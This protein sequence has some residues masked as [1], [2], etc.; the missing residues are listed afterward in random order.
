VLILPTA[1]A[2]SLGSEELDAVISHELAHLR[3]R[4]HW[5]RYLELAAVVVFWWNPASWWA[6]NGVR[7]AEEECC[8]A[9]V[10]RSC[11]G[12]SGAYARG[13]VKTMGFLAGADTFFPAVVTGA[14]HFQR[15]ERRIRM[16]MTGGFAR[17]VSAPLWAALSVVAL[18]V[19]LIAPTMAARTEPSAMAADAGVSALTEEPITL[20]L[21]QAVLEDMLKNLASVAELNLL[22]DS[23]VTIGSLNARVSCDYHATPLATVLDDLVGQAGLAWTLDGNVL[24]IH[25]PGQAPLTREGI[26]GRPITLNLRGADLRQVLATMEEIT[27]IHFE[28]DPDVQGT[29][30]VSFVDLPWDQALDLILKANGCAWTSENGGIRVFRDLAQG[31]IPAAVALPQSPPRPSTGVDG[32]QVYHYVKGGEITEPVR[33]HAPQPGY[34]PEAR[35]ARIQGAVVLETVIDAGGRVGTI[36]VLRGLPLGLTEAA[37][38]A[39]REWRFN[40]ATLDGVPVAVD[41]VLAVRF[42][43]DDQAP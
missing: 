20:K 41:Y 21:D 40:P 22:V 23:R 2:S 35:A 36:K 13:L 10:A 27:G 30:T 38:E 8:D 17:T 32:T 43:L 29:V 1:L 5:V 26:A 39:V 28:V 19:L 12:S 16:I 15:I 6:S 18:S 42:R 9:L 34:T 25:S 7:A 31:R 24:W 3:R 11:P 37:V 33:Q 4:D 14:S